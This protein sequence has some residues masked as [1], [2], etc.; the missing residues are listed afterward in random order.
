MENKETTKR[1]WQKG[2]AIF[3]CAAISLLAPLNLQ[4]KQAVAQEPLQKSE[5]VLIISE[6]YPPEFEWIFHVPIKK[7]RSA[8]INSKNEIYNLCFVPNDD[9]GEIVLQIF[10]WDKRVDRVKAILNR[11]IPDDFQAFCSS[12]IIGILHFSKD[13]DCKKAWFH[14]DH[15]NKVLFSYFALL[16]LQHMKTK[17]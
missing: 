5:Q 9:N 17:P 7:I 3:L 10:Y 2:I 12:R 11:T 8:T 16:A 1:Y 14:K 15:V 13:Y 4:T 6:D